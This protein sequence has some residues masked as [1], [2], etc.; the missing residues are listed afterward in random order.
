MDPQKTHVTCQT[1]SSL[2]RYQHWEWRG[3]RKHSLIYFC[4][5]NRVY[6][7]V[8]WQRVDQLRYNMC[9]GMY[10]THIYSLITVLKY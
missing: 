9:V 8:A 6:G 1:A 10:V 2:F 4:M 3:H 5:L 7:A